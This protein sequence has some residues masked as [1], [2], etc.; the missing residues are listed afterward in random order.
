M[1]LGLRGIGHK[2]RL[3]RLGLFSLELLTVGKEIYYAYKIMRGIDRVGVQNIFLLGNIK[4]YRAQ[5]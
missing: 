4:Y 1:M 2:E 3:N 5:L